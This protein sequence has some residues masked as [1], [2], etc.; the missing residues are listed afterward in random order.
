MARTIAENF[1][2]ALADL[3]SDSDI[4]KIVA[5][6]AEN[7]QVGNVVA[8][9]NFHG[10]EGAH[11]FWTNYR[12]TFGEVTSVY[13]N[14]IFTDNRAALEWTTEGKNKD[15]QKI[16]YEGTSILEIEGE[17]ITRFYAYFDP[18]KIGKQITKQE[19]GNDEEPEKRRKS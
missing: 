10:T 4:E 16:K 15:G 2:G 7:C 6:F 12:D 9:E 8:G 1:I 3:E 5:L 17:K 19:D 11:D 13:K 18:M 14:K